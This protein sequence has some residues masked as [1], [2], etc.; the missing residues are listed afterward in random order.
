MT[1]VFFNGHSLGSDTGSICSFD[2]RCDSVLLA[3]LPERSLSTGGVPAD[4]DSFLPISNAVPG[5]FGVLAA[6]PK[7]AN[8]P[9]PSPNAEEAPGAGAALLVFIG[10][11]P[12]ALFEESPD[13]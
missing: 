11:R 6:D 1:Q 5:V 9:E 7:A 10:G 2:A 13:T 4:D 8:A 12:L 3:P